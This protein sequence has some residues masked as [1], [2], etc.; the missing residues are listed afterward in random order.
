MHVLSDLLHATPPPPPPTICSWP[1]HNL[2]QR[3]AHEYT[4]HSGHACGVRI[5]CCTNLA[6]NGWTCLVPA[7][8]QQRQCLKCTLKPKLAQKTCHHQSSRAIVK[9][10]YGHQSSSSGFA[11]RIRLGRMRAC[12]E[13][14]LCVVAVTDLL[15]AAIRDGPAG[16]DASCKKRPGCMR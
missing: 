10:C 9:K 11:V 4:S 8:A 7:I 13:S 12:L 5:P 16:R 15:A 1:L 2:G 14:G 3:S 6:R